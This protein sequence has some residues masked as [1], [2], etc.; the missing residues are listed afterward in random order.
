[1]SIKNYLY[2]IINSGVKFK[3]SKIKIL[4]HAVQVLMIKEHFHYN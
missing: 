4:F 1:M 3:V 2:Y